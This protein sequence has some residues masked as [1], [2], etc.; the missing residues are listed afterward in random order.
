MYV[1][2]YKKNN[3]K[4]N[5]EIKKVG[6]VLKNNENTSNRVAE[7]LQELNLTLFKCHQTVSMK[8]ADRLHQSIPFVSS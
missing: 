4:I 1:K 3:M 7:S 6:D 5:D 8:C 2:K